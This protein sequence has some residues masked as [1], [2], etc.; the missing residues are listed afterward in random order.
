MSERRGLVVLADGIQTAFAAGAVATLARE[1]LRWSMGRGA[2]LGAQVAALA[3]LGEAEEG[4]RRWRRQGELGCPLLTPLLEGARHRL[5]GSPVTIVPDAWRIPGWLDDALLREHLAPEAAALPARLRRVGA[6]LEVAICD[7]AEGASHWVG[8]ETR[9][10]SGAAALIEAAARFPGG[11][12]PAAGAAGMPAEL[13]WGGTGATPADDLPTAAAWDVVCGFP[14]PAVPRAGGSQAIWET[15][16]RRDELQAGRLVSGWVSRDVPLVRLVAPSEGTLRLA[17]R[18]PDAELGVE[19]P[20]PWERNGELCGVLVRMGEA[21]AA[22][23][24]VSGPD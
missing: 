6:R 22:R 20:L 23:A 7:L 2:G 13:L 3:V 10:P 4:A 24:M 14:V 12:G 11:W 5:G 9:E 17:S 19:Y 18:R 1:G 15:L 21:A 16:Q 8:L